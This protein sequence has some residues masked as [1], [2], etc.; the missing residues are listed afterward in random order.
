MESYTIIVL[1]FGLIILLLLV[2]LFFINRLSLY[3]RRIDNSLITVSD[4]L[5]MRIKLIDEMIAFIKKNLEHEKSYVKK[6]EQIKK[7]LQAFSKKKPSFDNFN[8]NENN[9][10]HFT[11]LE[12]TYTNLNKNEEY[13]N[14]KE[15]ALNNQDKLIY[16]LDEFDKGVAQYNDYRSKKINLLISKLFFFPKYDC[17]KNNYDI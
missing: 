16:A 9:F 11:T 15:K 2:V 4:T 6:L 12:K 8:Q 13:L 5:D 17:Y 7:Y 14:L 1:I 3:R 10:L